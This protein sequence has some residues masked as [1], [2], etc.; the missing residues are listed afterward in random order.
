[1]VIMPLG[2]VMWFLL[3]TFCAASAALL[4]V[5]GYAAIF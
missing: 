4:L 1:M 5:F 2:A 3:A